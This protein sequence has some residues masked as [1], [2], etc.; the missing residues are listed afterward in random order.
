MINKIWASD[1]QKDYVVGD[2]DPNDYH[3]DVS[4]L[5]LFVGKNNSGKSRLIRSLFAASD[6]NISY[7]L[8]GDNLPQLKEE[9]QIASRNVPRGSGFDQISG[10]TIDDLINTGSLLLQSQRKASLALTFALDAAKDKQGTW[11]SKNGSP[12]TIALCGNLN[13]FTATHSR[14]LT[15]NLIQ[16]EISLAW[17]YI[18]ILRGLRPINSGDHGYLKRTK[19]DYFSNNLDVSK[20]IYTGEDLYDVL[21]KHLL[22]EPEHREKIK[23]Y[24]TLLSEQFFEGQSVALIPKHDH[25]VVNLKIGGEPQYPI[26]QLGDGLQQVIIITSGAYLAE[27]TSLV[28]I[29]EPETCL[30][31]GLLRQ[32]MKFLLDHTDHQYFVTTHSNHLLELSDESSDVITHKLNKVYKGDATRFG[33]TKI[34]QDR[35]LLLDLGVKSS[36][37]YLANCTVW[38]EGVTDRLYLRSFLKR[39]I[40]NLRDSEDDRHCTFSRYIENYHYAFVEYQGGNLTHWSFDGG[41][42]SM[43]GLDALSVTSP[44]FLIA[45]G[46]IKDKGGR[47]AKLEKQLGDCFFLLKGKEIENLIPEVILKATAK[48]L[49]E[50]FTREKFESNI[51]NIDRLKHEMYVNSNEGIGYHLDKCL[52]LKG[53]GRKGTHLIF[54]DNSGTIKD[55]ARFC[56]IATTMMDSDAEWELSVEVSGLCEKLLEHTRKYNE[57]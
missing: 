44:I 19:Q 32:L 7:T 27:E 24:E 29:E 49:F 13:N 1:W 14:N 5:N 6:Q 50:S 45:D 21:T 53:K 34:N 43:E 31:P 3:L 9:L 37:I 40:E 57:V 15:S 4:R 12:N 23:K 46:D 26:H 38:V 35:E 16:N 52:G 28:M 18:P 55:K 2:D 42:K 41:N 36:S 10:D 11:T 33:V 54:A 48:K 47:A 39:Y 25:D 20:S 8:T 56:D 30:H 51:D 17:I 22:G